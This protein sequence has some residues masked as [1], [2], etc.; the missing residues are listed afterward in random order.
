MGK[1]V[2]VFSGVTVGGRKLKRFESSD[3]S[4]YPI[5]GD[6]VVIFAGAKVLGGI[7]IGDRVTV[8][9]NSVVIDSVQPGATVAG[10]PA[11]VIS[12][13]D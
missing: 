11:R 13:G 7:R 9:A 8:G 5:I 3:S 6:N 2:K 4:R 12:R 10:I 1:M